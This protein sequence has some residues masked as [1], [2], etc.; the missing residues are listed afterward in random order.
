[1][2]GMKNIDK[3]TVLRLKEQVAYQP[4]Q[5]VSRTLAQNDALSVTLFSFDKDEEISTH[6]SGGDAFVT[7]LDGVGR[8][9]ID[10]VPYELHEGDSI[11]M[12]AGHPHAV[13]GQEQF[14]MLL[15]VVFNVRWGYPRA[16]G[17]FAGGGCFCVGAVF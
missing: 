17:A 9:T 4:G 11:V 8:I 6:A 5:V 3:S 16:G 10:G 15:V 1:M 7:C 14:K 2:N 12:P 13:Y